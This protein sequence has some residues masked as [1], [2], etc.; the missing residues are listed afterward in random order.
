MARSLSVPRL[1][2]LMTVPLV[3]PVTLGRRLLRKIHNLSG[4]E[5]YTEHLS[6]EVVHCGVLWGTR[7]ANTI[8]I[9]FSKPK[10]AVH[11]TVKRSKRTGR[12]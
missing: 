12:I 10:A 3:F 7:G 1:A 6:S 9:P 11:V 8:P 5:G 2:Q 4:A